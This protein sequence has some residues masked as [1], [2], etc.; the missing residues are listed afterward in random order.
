MPIVN[1]ELKSIDAERFTERGAAIKNIRVDHNSSVTR[2][3]QVDKDNCIIGFRF[4]ANYK[5][6]GRIEIEGQLVYQGD[7]VSNLASYWSKENQMPSNIANEVHST[8][9]SNCIPEAVFI[10]RDLQ[11]PPP[12]PLP[13]VNIPDPKDTGKKKRKGGM[14][15]A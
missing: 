7:N 14:E 8:V 9:I 15:V 4:T 6:M 3:T 11:L 10:A 2:M 13:K 5:G 1:F 12:I